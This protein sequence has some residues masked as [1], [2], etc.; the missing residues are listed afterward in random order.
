MNKILENI[1]LILL[2]MKLASC[3]IYSFSG[4]SIPA[5][6]KTVSIIRFN[7]NTNNSAPSLEQILT[8]KLK[9]IFIEQ[10][11]LSLSNLKGDLNFNGSIEKYEIKPISI[12]SNETASQNRLTI[13][14]RVNY[15]NHL[16]KE[17]NFEE[18]FSRYKDFDGSSNITEIETE[19]I[20]E[21]TEQ[22]V[23]DIFNKATVNW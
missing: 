18:T 13:S 10:T 17:Y 12:N 11:N 21:I 20:D 8:E 4:S 2:M 14:V 9:D 7:N 16:M 5:N 1:I 15:E 22:I 23:E 3:G 19:I 6:A